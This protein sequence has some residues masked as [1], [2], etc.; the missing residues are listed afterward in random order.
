MLPNGENAHITV[1]HP[2]WW[3]GS[4]DTI[5]SNFPN[6]SYALIASTSY[7]NATIFPEISHLEQIKHQS[8]IALE[9]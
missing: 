8:F 1:R 2:L 4:I 3:K 6:V 9:K 5:A 7:S